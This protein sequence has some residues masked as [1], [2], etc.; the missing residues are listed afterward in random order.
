[1]WSRG[2]GGHAQNGSG[3]SGE[4]R[5]KIQRCGGRSPATA[6]ARGIPAESRMQIAGTGWT[7]IAGVGWTKIAGTGWTKIAGVGEGRLGEGRLG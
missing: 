6:D 7:K 4:A 3:K 5:D 1:M 2:D